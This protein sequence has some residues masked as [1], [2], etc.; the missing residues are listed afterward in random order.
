MKMLIRSDKASAGFDRHGFT[1]IELLAILAVCAL[2]ILIQI[3]AMARA[4]SASKR[5]QCVSNLR[6]FSDALHILA[7]E[8]EG[9]LPNYP[10]SGFWAWDAPLA[11]GTDIE[12][13]GAH[14]S[15]MYCPGTAPRF[16]TADNYYLYTN[17][18]ALGY[19]HTLPGSSSLLANNI[20]YS[21][22]PPRIQI[23]FGVFTTPS[24]SERVV[25]ADAT[26]SQAGQS[27]MQLADNY[28]FVQISGG[29][30]KS[31]LSAHLS[32]RL[33]A[34]GNLAMMDGHIEWRAF[35]KMVARTTVNNPV[36]WW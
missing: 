16:T 9:R 4:N 26:I 22:S 2:L 15:V 24:T 25:L 36:F 17:W 31:H 30:P 34:G 14:W 1:V 6:Q 23:S 3:P 11:F 33:P 12:R 27:N 7:N 8:N 32:G 35:Q 13:T 28:N 20:N 21:M 18:R 19:V 29:S 10:V 5:V